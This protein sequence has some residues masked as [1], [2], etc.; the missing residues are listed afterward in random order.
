MIVTPFGDLQFGDKMAL[1]YWMDAHDQQ[2]HAERLAIART[3][4]PLFPRSFQSPLTAEWFGRHMIEHTALKDF[5]QPDSTASSVMLESMWENADDFNKW[6][7]IHNL[8]HQRID[9]S[10]GIRT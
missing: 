4:V 8:L 7:Q 9:Q 6:H 3:G 10:L 1:Q 5:A 2:H